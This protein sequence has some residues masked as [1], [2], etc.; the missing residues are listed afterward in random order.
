MQNNRNNAPAAR[1]SKR[2]ARLFFGLRG[3]AVAGDIPYNGALW[4]F[5]GNA[6]GEETV[7][8]RRNGTLS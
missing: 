5:V 3:V 1:I 6:A 4:Y 8:S 7:R 2:R